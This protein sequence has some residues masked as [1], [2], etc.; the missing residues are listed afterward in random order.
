MVDMVPE[1]AYRQH[2]SAGATHIQRSRRDFNKKTAG[3]QG[4][5]A[6]LDTWCLGESWNQ[7][8]H[9][10]LVEDAEDSGVPI[11]NVS[12][13]K[14]LTEKKNVTIPSL[15]KLRHHTPPK[16][17]VAI[18]GWSY[19]TSRDVGRYVLPDNV[20]AIIPQL[21]LC[22]SPELFLL[23]VVCSAVANFKERAAIRET[24]ASFPS[25][26][27]SSNSVRVAFLLGEP[28][29][30]TLQD[31]VEEESFQY[32]DIVQEGFVDSY[33]NLTLK[34]VMML[35]WVSTHCRSV[36]YIMKTD[37]DMFVNINNLLRLLR[38]RA[39]SNL[40]VGALICGARPIADT[41]NK[42][43]PTHTDRYLHKTSNHHPGQKRAMM[44]TLINRARRVAEPRHILSHVSTALMANGYSRPE[45]KR[46]MRP[47]V[48]PS[49]RSQER[50]TKKGTVFLPYLRNVTDRISRVLKHH[51]V[52]TT[53]LP[54]KQIRNML[55]SSKDKLH[56][57]R[58]L[59]DFLTQLNSFHTQVQFTM[60]TEKDG[61]L[62]FLDVMVQRRTDGTLG[63]D[64][65][66]KPTHTDRYLHKTSKHHPGLKRAMMK[67][68]INRARRV[69]E[70]RHIQRELSHVSTALM[71][72]GYSRPEI[73]R[74]MRPRVTPSM[75]SQE[76]ATKKGTVFLPYLRNVTDR[77]SRVLKRHEVETT[78]LPTKQIRNMLR[79]SKDKRDKLLSAGVYRIP[80]SCGKVYI[81]TTQRSVRTRLTEH[82]RNC[83]LGQIDK[84]AVAAYAYQEGDHNIRFKDTD[85]LSTT[86]HFFPVYIEKRSKYINI[87]T[88]IARK[89]A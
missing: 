20:T 30:S 78:F 60:E 8:Q 39:V 14:L 4:S 88:L 27:N 2:L 73:K 22:S 70:P 79:S 56:G 15:V 74:A 84:S 75:R 67:T 9:V 35:K 58:S 76:R 6:P 47:R 40:L 83:R 66:R 54:T 69:A 46:A 31:L 59:M 3:D 51:E 10:L 71:A 24:W 87:T 81:G 7:R 82:N 38:P 21:D 55:R 62:P 23:V 57:E 29:N 13:L 19:N 77:I 89:K 25:I 61:R 64:V 68:L 33:N 37:D 12:H 17:K 16:R 53:F 42:W 65:Y 48:T 86:T 85:I 11:C 43:K 18:P 26:T 41:Q 34:S 50:A 63:H 72:N 52:E 44:K 49:M 80:C 5:V 1:S 45:I 28:D 32:S 36:R